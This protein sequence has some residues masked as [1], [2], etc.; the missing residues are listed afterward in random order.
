[1][2]RS[3]WSILKFLR[4]KFLKFK[5]SEKGMFSA[6]NWLKQ[7]ENKYLYLT[8]WELEHLFF[9]YSFDLFHTIIILGIFRC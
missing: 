6:E 5:S 3:I 4:H 1:M 9:I 7:L 2:I 8:L